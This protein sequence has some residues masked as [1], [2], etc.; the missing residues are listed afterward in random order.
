MT[1]PTETLIKALRILANDIQSEDGV[2]NT[3]ILEAAQR[4]E[5]DQ[6]VIF[7]MGE[8]IKILRQ[9]VQHRNNTIDEL[10]LRI[11][12]LE[13]AGNDLDSWLDRE[14]PVTIRTNWKQAKEAKP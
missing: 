1:T 9:T 14:T 11:K 5:E 2:A 12:R 10:K 13:A 6:Q 7:Q 8:S 3:A 4:M